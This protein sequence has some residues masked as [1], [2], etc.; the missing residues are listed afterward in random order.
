MSF[1]EIRSRY[2]NW[3]KKQLNDISDI[4][5]LGHITYVATWK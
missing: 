1:V 5:I 3:L 4:K 2:R